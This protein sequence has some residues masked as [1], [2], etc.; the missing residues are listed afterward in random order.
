MPAFLR[1]DDHAVPIVTATHRLMGADSGL[2]EQ[3]LFEINNLQ[4]ATVE[5]DDAAN[6][7]RC[8]AGIAD[9]LDASSCVL[10]MADVWCQ[11]RL[12]CAL[13]LRFIQ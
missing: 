2:G 6:I 12:T 3:F 5:G 13:V 9:L 11:A 7:S 4:R 1:S 10:L 8:L